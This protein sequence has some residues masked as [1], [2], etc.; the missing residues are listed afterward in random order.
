VERPHRGEP[1]GPWEIL[2]E[3]E[4]GSDAVAPEPAANQPPLLVVVKVTDELT[5]C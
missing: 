5:D 3:R 4:R 2:T 1:A